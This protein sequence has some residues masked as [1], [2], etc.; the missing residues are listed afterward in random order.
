MRDLKLYVAAAT[1][2][3]FACLAV[4]AQQ[5]SPNPAPDAPQPA[6]NPSA[7]TQGAPAAQ[8]AEGA[9]QSTAPSA[10]VQSTASAPEASSAD[11]RPVQGELEKKVDTKNAKTG[12]TV[13]VKTTEQATTAG[14]VVIPK[15]SR[16]LGHVTDVQAH[17]K[18]N[19]NAKLTLQF[20]QAELK[21]G[22]TVPIKSVIQSVAPAPQT[23]APTDTLNSPSAMGAPA[24]PTTGSA[25]PS[26]G[27]G[28]TPGGMRQTPATSENPAPTPSTEASSQ[29]GAS[30]GNTASRSAGETGT[31]VA[32]QGNVDIKTTAIP[33]VLLAVAANGQPFSNASGALLGAKQNVRLDGGTR[34]ELAVAD[35]GG[36][37]ASVR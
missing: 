5:P 2:A 6:Q 20:D 4:A 21:G 23:V 28:G 32:K 35:A 27:G 31:V 3:G 17:D 36:K 11:L 9:K 26:S 30:A 8:P 10:P 12:D 7:Q 19:E 14:G 37:G 34:V 24:A 33:G 25:M 16:I 18:N 13:V 15:G 29:G 1:L 22:E